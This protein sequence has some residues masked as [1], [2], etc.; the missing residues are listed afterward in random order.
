MRY[1]LSM[2]KISISWVLILILSA[3]S[4]S[5]MK[6]DFQKAMELAEE[7]NRNL[8]LLRMDNKTA[9]LQVKEAYSAALPVITAMGSYYYN[10][11]IPEL[12]TKF[13]MNGEDVEFV[14][15]L[16]KVHNYYA[17][18]DL[19]QPLWLAGKVGIG[20]RIAKI[21]REISELGVKQGE[22]DLKLAV[23]QAFYGALVTDDFVELMNETMSQI[24]KHLANV[25][26]MHEQGVIAEYDVLRAEVELANFEPQLTEAEE[27]HKLAIEGLRITLGLEPD[28]EFELV[29]EINDFVFEEVEMDEAVKYALM[30]RSDFK[31][32]NSQ[33]KMLD[34]LLKLEKRNQFWPNLFL[35]ANLKRQ[36]QEDDLE[37]DNYF[38]GDGLSA[39]VSIQIPLFDGFKTRSRIQQ[40]KINLKKNEIM[41]DQ[42]E[43]GIRME[44]KTAVWDLQK[45]YEKLQSSR[46]AVQ[47]AE[48]GYSIA[49]VRYASGIST[50]I[51]LL[52]A[53]L[54]NTQSSVNELYALFDLISAKAAYDRALGR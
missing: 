23:T 10:F 17:A 51:E 30:N 25:K 38:W 22:S 18:I 1:G 24:Q 26:A 13:T 50:Q 48:K 46:K 11:I 16:E 53:R 37:F 40:A 39:G 27:A 20:L 45:A 9:D 8:Q 35:T 14:M 12:R 19:K 42:V 32:L 31:Q 6:I 52:D 43:D 5:T 3:V 4:W 49:E 36:A 28:T 21:Y 29:G 41:I 15:A 44:V 34:Q 33:K 2:R 54:V 47:Q 7:N